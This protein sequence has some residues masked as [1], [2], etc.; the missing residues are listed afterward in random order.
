MFKGEY[1][2]GVAYAH[3]AIKPKSQK[4]QFLRL[5]WEKA[6][7]THQGWNISKWRWKNSVLKTL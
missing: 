4:S 3:L 2:L 5:P 6:I 1:F 7:M